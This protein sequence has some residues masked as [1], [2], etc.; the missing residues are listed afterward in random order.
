VKASSS[1]ID[2]HRSSIMGDFWW[3]GRCCG[4]LSLAGCRKGREK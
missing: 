1:I 3:C 2:H 4:R